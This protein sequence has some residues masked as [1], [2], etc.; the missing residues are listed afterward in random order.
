M[1]VAF[2]LSDILRAKNPHTYRPIGEIEGLVWE[3]NIFLRVALTIIIYDIKYKI[4][5]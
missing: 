2:L 5:W 3:K 4:S 1:N